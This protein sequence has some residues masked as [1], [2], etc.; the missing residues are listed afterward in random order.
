MWQPRT[1]QSY[2]NEQS[3]LRRLDNASC[4]YANSMQQEKFNIFSQFFVTTIKY[5]MDEIIF[6]WSVLSHYLEP[7]FLL[8]LPFLPLL[9][10]GGLDVNP[11][12]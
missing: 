9:A 2:M 1:S 8:L 5:V 10:C 11:R 7:F 3:I 6:S 4:C 12:K